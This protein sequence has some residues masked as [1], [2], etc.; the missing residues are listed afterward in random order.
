MI[1]RALA[2]GVDMADLEIALG[3][4]SSTILRLAKLKNPSPYSSSFRGKTEQELQFM[5]QVVDYANNTSI[6]EASAKF[7]INYASVYR[8]R[9]TLFPGNDA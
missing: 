3:I 7:D 6:A 9:R 1:R 5:R 8:W 4:D 2:N